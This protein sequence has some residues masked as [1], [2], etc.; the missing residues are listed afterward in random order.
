MYVVI[1][2]YIDQQRQ[3]LIKINKSN[4]AGVKV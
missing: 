3:D 4:E 2:W 1:S